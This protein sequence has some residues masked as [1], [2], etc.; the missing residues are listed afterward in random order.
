MSESQD[1]NA[2]RTPR[3]VWGVGIFALLWNA[4]GGVDFVMTQS[5]NEEYLAQFTP[6]Q[7][8]FFQG[9]PVW[10]VAAWGIAVWGSVLGSVLLLL[11]KSLAAPVF[12]VA[13]VAMLV[14]T[15][16]NFV[17]ADGL[18]VMGGT[19]ELVFSGVIFAV[20]LLLWVYARALSRRGVL[21]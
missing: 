14:T 9:L 16:H 8:E 18:E 21:S 11:R 19:F 15:F 5:G 6:E 7:R 3:H 10:V 20:G 1:S 2:A 4:M 17:L 12:L 13:F